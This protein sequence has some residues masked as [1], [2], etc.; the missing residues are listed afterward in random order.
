[1]LKE[2]WRLISRIERIGDN[3]IIVGAFFL[4]YFGRDSL[5]FWNQYFDLDLN[6][7]GPELAP[8]KDNLIV[9]G[10][11]LVLYALALNWL[12]AYGSMRMS[13]SWRILR[14]SILSSAVTFAGIAAVL[15]LVKIDL[16]RSFIIL[17]L[18]LCALGLTLQRFVVLNV[19]RYW[20]ARGKN[21]RNLVICGVGEQACALAQQIL[22]RPELGVRLLG[23]ADLVPRIGHGASDA[24]TVGDGPSWE[25]RSAI[26]A[27]V[28]AR[29]KRRFCGI[30]EL[31]DALTRHAIDEVMFTDV[32]Q[33]MPQVEEMIL[34]CSE[35]GVRTTIV[36][37]LFSMRMVKS[38]VS[39][40]GDTA[41]IHYQTPPGDRWELV[42]KRALDILLASLALLVLSPVFLAISLAIK[43]T[44]P[45]P[46]VFR[47]KRVGLHGRV[48]TLYKF[49]SMTEDAERRQADLAAV[50]EMQGPVFKIKDDP[51]ITSIGHLLRRFSLDELPQLWNVLRGDMSLVGPRPPLPS[52]VDRY[53]RHYKRRLSMRPG[54]TCTWQVSGRNDISNFDTWVRLDLEYIDNWSLSN[55]LRLIARTVPAVLFGD[56]AR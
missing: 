3:L 31:E 29:G 47:Q 8:V 30:A 21:F 1:M 49:R 45:G 52:E 51:R 5:L 38:A 20:R 6:F 46:V 27:A 11:A 26:F 9:L 15:F 40:F 54:L 34:I 32:A 14:T 25:E 48:F 7:G 42:I 44:S 39:Y 35:Q 18:V 19:L 17:F 36:A 33:V 12:G 28:P 37:D 16:S 13:S 55:D 24:S 56:G 43:L 4:A 2:N 50:N 23:F 22:S 53:V 10:S 41:L